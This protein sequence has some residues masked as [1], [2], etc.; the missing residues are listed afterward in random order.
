MFIY[1]VISAFSPIKSVMFC[2]CACVQNTWIVFFLHSPQ[3]KSKITAV[4]CDAPKK[5]R[6][7]VC[8][9]PGFRC[10]TYAKKLTP[11]WALNEQEVYFLLISPGNKTITL[12]KNALYLQK[13]TYLALCWPPLAKKLDFSVPL[14]M[15][16]GNRQKQGGHELVTESGSKLQGVQGC[17]CSHCS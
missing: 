5:R 16:V 15:V 9:M 6:R 7:D 1:V 4:T 11:D 8:V 2:A 14:T 12:T 10:Q 17:A 13:K 3:N